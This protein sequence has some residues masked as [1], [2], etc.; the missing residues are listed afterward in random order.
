MINLKEYLGSG[1]R[2]KNIVITGGTTGIGKAAAE[3]LISLGARVLIF[4]RDAADFKQA[5]DEITGRFPQAELFGAPADVTNEDDIN[6][7]MDIVDLQ[8]GSIDILINNAA[9]PGEGIT[10][11][12]R[13]EWKYIIQTNFIGY[14]DFA[15]QAVSRMKFQKSGH[16]VNIGSMSAETREQTGTIYVATKAAIRGFT[17][18]LRKEVNP[19]GIK[20]TLI[21]PG[22]V[23]TDLQPGTKEEHR[24]KIAELEMLHPQDIAMSILFAVSQAPRCDII[25]MQVRP[26]LQLI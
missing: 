21:E 2:Y 26:H 11:T 17:A 14:V 15:Q 13:D 5:F 22:S 23:M 25:S 6:M 18:A 20:V 3:L 4:G 12:G 7:I 8:M 19:L 9:V 24:E 16:I 10:N 1:I